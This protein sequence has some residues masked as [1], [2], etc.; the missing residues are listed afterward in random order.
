MRSSLGGCG[1]VHGGVRGRAPYDPPVV[2]LD[3]ALDR[4]YGGI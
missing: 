2:E 3:D 4:A 1:R